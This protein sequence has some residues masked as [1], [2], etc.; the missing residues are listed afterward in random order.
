[1]AAFFSYL[2]NGASPEANVNGSV[3]P[4]VFS[5]TA[6]QW[7]AIE[8]MIVSIEDT[9]TVG[10]DDYGAIASGLSNGIDVELVNSGTTT[11]ILDG[12][13]VQTNLD[14]AALCYD[15]TEPTFSG[16]GNKA[17]VVRWTF[18]KSGAPLRLIKD[19]VFRIRINDN[20]T[21]LIRHRFQIQGVIGYKGREW[22]P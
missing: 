18:A 15:A 2:K 17:V 3:T 1:M 5:Y 11:D 12:L 22:G 20:C 16:G 13:P 9:G 8:R 7:C 19:D 14:W 21:G 6:P 10:A 4:V